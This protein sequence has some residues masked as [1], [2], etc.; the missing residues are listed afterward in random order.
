MRRERFLPLRVSKFG[1]ESGQ[2]EVS[3]SKPQLPKGASKYARCKRGS[4]S[5]SKVG[6]G[7]RVQVVWRKIDRRRWGP[8]MGQLKV[9]GIFVPW[10]CTRT[11]HLALPVR[12]DSEAVRARGDGEKDC[13]QI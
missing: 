10:R 6:V 13:V 9:K 2:S 5:K 7:R 3:I 8:T 11:Y 4:Q 1:L 12:R